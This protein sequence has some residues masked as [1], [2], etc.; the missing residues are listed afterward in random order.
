M[1]KAKLFNI[2]KIISTHL[3][4]YCLLLTSFAPVATLATETGES[5][6]TATPA[7][8]VDMSNMTEADIQA[9]NEADPTTAQVTAA[10]VDDSNNG[11]SNLDEVDATTSM[12]IAVISG[13]AIG[14]VSASMLRVCKKITTDMYIAAAAG[15]VYIYG[16]IQ[17]TIKDKETRE[18][19]EDAYDKC[20]NEEAD[21]QTGALEAEMASYDEIQETADEKAKLHEYSA[22]ALI[23]AAGLALYKGMGEEAAGAACATDLQVTS[24]A[25]AS[26]APAWCTAKYIPI[27][28]TDTNAVPRAACITDLEKCATG[29]AG[30]LGFT[31]EEAAIKRT[32]TL[33]SVQ[34]AGRE[35]ALAVEKSTREGACIGPDSSAHPKVAAIKAPCMQ[36]ATFASGNQS[37][38][39]FTALSVVSTPYGPQIFDSKRTDNLL[40]KWFELKVEKNKKLHALIPNDKKRS[41]FVEFWRK[42]YFEG[43][44]IYSPEAQAG[45]E[46]FSSYMG[47]AGAAVGLWLG[48][49]KTTDTS[50]NLFIGTPLGRATFF[51]G[52]GALVYY[53]ATVTRDIAEQAKTNS[54]KIKSV[55]N[56]FKDDNEG[57]EIE[58]QG[59]QRQDVVTTTGTTTAAGNTAVDDSGGTP[60]LCA[61]GSNASGGCNQ[62]PG[63]GSGDTSFLNGFLGSNGA[64]GLM[65]VANDANNGSLSPSSNEIVNSSGGQGAIALKKL[66]KMK[67]DYLSKLKK[68]DEK[69]FDNFNKLDKYAG[70]AIQA[71]VSK[72]LKKNNVTPGQFLAAVG[73][74]KMPSADDAKKNKRVA[75]ISNSISGKKVGSV[76]LGG[77]DKSSKAWK[78]NFDFD[79]KAKEEVTAVSGNGGDLG[80][81]ED[82]GTTIGSHDADDIIGRNQNIFDEITKRYIRTAYPV[83]L[84]RL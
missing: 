78:M 13:I 37:I 27:V 11:Q 22:A 84:D 17:A 68:T 73:T 39:E 19:I 23:T 4:T 7:P 63:V 42:A 82:N 45:L 21:C 18:E 40:K 71:G 53:S 29:L 8:T 15:I 34:F 26:T 33:S 50:F 30:A 80:L 59:R 51:G 55:L 25:L 6:A 32:P 70:N 76:S 81:S 16:E 79:D 48:L 46:S 43:M 44:D 2:F 56:N 14:Y 10:A 3:A 69:A 66:R 47:F 52:M 75:A 5:E 54:D 65:Q 1:K 77:S 31:L 38:C 60:E 49:K 58:R 61:N 83:L 72:V 36:Y 62:I 35:K 64:S 20:K 41:Q 28:P 9:M 24:G 67:K 57:T 74:G 12:W